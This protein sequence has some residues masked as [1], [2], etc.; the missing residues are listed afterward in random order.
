MKGE[1]SGFDFEKGKVM[2]SYRRKRKSGSGA[3]SAG[4][5]GNNGANQRSR[6]SIR[7]IIRFLIQWTHKKYHKIVLHL[8]RATGREGA[9]SFKPLFR[10]ERR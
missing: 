1:L 3:G 2:L 8:A 10:E 9:C 6:E 5:W 7:N 4:D